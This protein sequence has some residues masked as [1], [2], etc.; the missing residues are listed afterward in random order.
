MQFE[1]LKNH[2][3]VLILGGTGDF[4]RFH[5]LIH[6]VNDRS[7]I[8]VDKEGVFLGLAYDFRKAFEGQRHIRKGKAGHP[9]ETGLVGFEILWPT[10]LIQSRMYREALGFIDSGKHHQVLAYSLEAT[11]EEGLA[12]DF[13]SRSG[14]IQE[15]YRMLDPGHPFLESKATSRIEHWYRWNKKEREARI[16]ELLESLD[17][18][19]ESMYQY[20]MRAGK[21]YSMSPAEWDAIESEGDESSGRPH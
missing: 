8:I 19:F 4:R 17:P 16:L 10:L 15:A 21:A 9:V 18:S 3:G 20:G 13:A 12:Q 2:E 7:P 1:L 6:D 5:E 11:V 14:V